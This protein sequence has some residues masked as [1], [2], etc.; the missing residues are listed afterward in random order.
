MEHERRERES[1][2]VRAVHYC[3]NFSGW[4]YLFIISYFALSFSLYPFSLLPLLLLLAFL[5]ASHFLDSHSCVC[6]RRQTIFISFLV[7]Q[8]LL[9]VVAL[10]GTCLFIL[11]SGELHSAIKT[12]KRTMKVRVYDSS[13]LSFRFWWHW[14]CCRLPVATTLFV[15]TSDKVTLKLISVGYYLLIISNVMLVI[16]IG[17]SC[18]AAIASNTACIQRLLSTIDRKKW[19]QLHTLFRDDLRHI[20]VIYA[21]QYPAI[22]LMSSSHRWEKKHSSV[23]PTTIDCEYIIVL[24]LHSRHI[25][26]RSLRSDV[27]LLVSP[28]VPYT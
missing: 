8:F 17:T 3:L 16:C 22:Q 15:S 11:S 14:C 23:Q 5:F 4:S 19:H 25:F 12:Q 18:H 9:F 28:V 6:A 13:V 21:R 26:F 20:R 7:W 2:D 10:N 1:F 27:V 24:Y